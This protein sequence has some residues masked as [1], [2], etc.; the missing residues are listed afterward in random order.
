YEGFDTALNRPVAVKVLREHVI[1]PSSVDRF[2]EEARLMASC[3]HLNIVGVYDFGFT[4]RDRPFLVME[5]LRGHTLRQALSAGGGPLEQTQAVAILGGMAGAIDTA[6][7]QGLLH[8]D[9]K[10]ENVW[11]ADDSDQP[12]TKLLDFGL[13]HAMTAMNGPLGGLV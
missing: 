3:V 1:Q 9:V 11:L 4:A 10:P 6:H 8:G 5:L 2:R 7:R 12:V 13:A